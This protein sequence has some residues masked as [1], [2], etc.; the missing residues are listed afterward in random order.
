MVLQDKVVAKIKEYEKNPSANAEKEYGK[1][2]PLNDSLD[3]LN[4][5]LEEL[6]EL[7]VYAYLY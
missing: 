2:T 3:A 6:N 4:N 1:R 7:H 5:K